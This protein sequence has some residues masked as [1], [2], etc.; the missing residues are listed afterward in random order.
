MSVASTEPA[1]DISTHPG[2]ERIDQAIADPLA[3]LLAHPLYAAVDRPERLRLFMENHAFAVWDFMSLLMRLQ[4]D[5]CGTATLWQPAASPELA[6]FINEIVLAE[7]SD[8]D[9]RGG[10]AS[11][12]ELYLSAMQER[13]CD[14][15]AINRWTAGLQQDEAWRTV[16]QNCDVAPATRAFVTHTL[17][18]VEQGSAAA[19][20]AAFCFGREDIIPEM[21]Q[22][23]VDTLQAAGENVSEL[24]YYLQ[25]HI[26]LD[27][28]T[29]G[30]M[31]RKLLLHACGEDESAWT[32]A[33][34]AAVRAIEMRIALWDGI[35]AEFA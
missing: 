4:R 11:H 6:R 16:L 5:V 31:S 3:R 14:S 30:P 29:H 27:G 10:Y 32:D 28:D 20:A 7:A 1:T 22:R 17:E 15:S 34:E 8:V 21:F 12:F 26:E 13:G 19:V 35:L 24:V 18:L 9:Q 2:L 33:R 25:R 23:L